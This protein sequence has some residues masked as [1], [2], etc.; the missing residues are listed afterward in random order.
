MTKGVHPNGHHPNSLK[1]LKPYVKG[2]KPTGGRPKGSVSLTD[3]IRRAAERDYTAQD[4]ITK[5]M[6]T[7]Q[8]RDW[9]GI[10]LAGKAMKGDIPAIKEMMDRLEG[11][12]KEKIEVTG[13]DGEPFTAQYDQ[14]LLDIYD[15]LETFGA[16]RTITIDAP[17]TKD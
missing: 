1:N 5:Q 2:K 10:A 11:K 8:I 4:P 17:P 14:R 12:V 6:E 16:E 3:A 15:R 7:K 9:V 13:K